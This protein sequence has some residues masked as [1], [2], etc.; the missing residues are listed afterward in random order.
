MRGG[1]QHRPRCGA[2]KVRSVSVGDKKSEVAGAGPV[3]RG[4]PSDYDVGRTNDLT[5]DQL[6]DLAGGQTRPCA[7]RSVYCPP[8]GPV[9]RLTTTDVMSRT[10]SAEM[11]LFPGAETS[12]TTEMARSARS[13]SITL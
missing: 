13:P 8:G 2:C 7:H 1:E 3:E 6:R 10:G 11:M 5:A 4:D 9:R 12:N